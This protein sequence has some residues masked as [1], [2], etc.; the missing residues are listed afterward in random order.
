MFPWASIFARAIFSRRYTRSGRPNGLRR[1]RFDTL[2]TY[3]GSQLGSMR[4][5]DGNIHRG[6]PREGYYA[7][8][9]HLGAM[10]PVIAGALM[11][12]R[13]RGEMG[14][15]GATCLGDEHLDRG[16]PRRYQCGRGREA[17]S[18]DRRGK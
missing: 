17:S 4:G 16:V 11:A 14:V 18:G 2:R 8:I 5:R 6:R 9:S 7:M 13:F 1:L 10:I 12:R 3:L 15:V